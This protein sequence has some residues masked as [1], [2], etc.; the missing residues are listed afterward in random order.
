MSK[1]L[2]IKRT[3]QKDNYFPVEDWIKP[4]KPIDWASIPTTLSE[5]RTMYTY[6][7]LERKEELDNT[8]EKYKNYILNLSYNWDGYGAQPFNEETLRRAYNL[9]ENILD[10]FWNDIIDIS[11]PLIQPVPDGSIDINWETDEFELLINISPES[12]KQVNLYGEKINSPEEEI[13]MHIPYDLVES[14]IIQWLIK[15]L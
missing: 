12:N 13:E 14:V 9:S 11:I 10:H 2:N 5:V 7:K 15:I 8:F 3:F 6:T 1:D 4:T